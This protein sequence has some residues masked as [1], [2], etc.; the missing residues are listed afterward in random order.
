MQ[1]SAEITKLLQGIRD[2]LDLLKILYLLDVAVDNYCAVQ[3]C[4]EKA[5]PLVKVFLD[6]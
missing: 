4:I 2:H 3:D 6:I 1:S 5:F